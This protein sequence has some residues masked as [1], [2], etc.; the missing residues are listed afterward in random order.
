MFKSTIILS[1]SLLLTLTIVHAQEP[2]ETK[3]PQL[4]SDS[5]LALR[6]ELF[7][8]SKIATGFFINN[9][10]EVLSDS[11]VAQF[12]ADLDLI[13]LELYEELGEKSYSLSA[14]QRTAFRHADDLSLKGCTDTNNISMIHTAKDA[15][16]Q[17]AEQIDKGQ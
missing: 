2:D 8:L 17:W 15:A 3:E 10:C 13:N 14:I 1:L 6:D 9:H 16:R 7:D 4:N 11:E 12:E 5:A